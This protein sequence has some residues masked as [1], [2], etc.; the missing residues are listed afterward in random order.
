MSLMTG[1]GTPPLRAALINR[2]SARVRSVMSRLSSAGYTVQFR[3]PALLSFAILE[4][5]DGFS[6]PFPGQ[7]IRKNRVSLMN[8]LV[9]PR[10]LD[11]I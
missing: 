3:D 2:A 7:M 1:V 9:S 11:I 8:N 10:H 5:D 6:T 4:C